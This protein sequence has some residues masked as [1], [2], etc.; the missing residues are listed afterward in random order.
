MAL[1]MLFLYGVSLRVLA[2]SRNMT[3]CNMHPA[4]AAS[5]SANAA[6]VGTGAYARPQHWVQLICIHSGWSCAHMPNAFRRS[7]CCSC[8]P[9]RVLVKL[10]QATGVGCINATHWLIV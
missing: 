3:S 1:A 6:A 5:S 2:H 4:C 8:E 10:K 9:Y 7:L